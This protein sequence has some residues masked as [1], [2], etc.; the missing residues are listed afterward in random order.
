VLALH[1]PLLAPAIASMYVP[2]ST[3]SY[4]NVSLGVPCSLLR[5]VPQLKDFAE[6][7]EAR[8]HVYAGSVHRLGCLLKLWLYGQ[9]TH[10]RRDGNMSCA[11]CA[12]WFR[13][14]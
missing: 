4:Q 3:I 8:C 11:V 12:L 14:C 7:A 2:G 6:V 13:L 1:D 5:D 9:S 10:G